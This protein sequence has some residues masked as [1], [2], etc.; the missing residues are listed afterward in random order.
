VLSLFLI[1]LGGCAQATRPTPT[2]AEIEEAQISTSRRYPYKTW[3][4]DRASR[5]F[6]RLLAT[7]P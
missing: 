4:L 2:A 7:V 6:I 3:S 1:L 5:I